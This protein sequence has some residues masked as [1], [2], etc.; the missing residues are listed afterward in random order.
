MSEKIKGEKHGLCNI[1][2]CQSPDEVI[3]YN[4]STRSYYCT[5]CAKRLNE[6]NKDDAEEMFGH[7]LCTRVIKKKKDPWARNAMTVYP[8]HKYELF[9]MAPLPDFN[10]QNECRN[11]D[12]TPKR[13]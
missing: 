12:G 6:V 5:V 7:P 10:Y 2:A 4:H 11:F 3:W 13:R 1:T 8:I 9:T